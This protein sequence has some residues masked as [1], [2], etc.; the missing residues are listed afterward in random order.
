MVFCRLHRFDI[1]AFFSDKS[2]NA[3]GDILSAFVKIKI[4]KPKKSGLFNFF[5]KS[6]SDKSING[7]IPRHT[8]Q[9][10]HG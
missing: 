6:I 2:E 10:I 1:M 3:N 5:K 4:L 9:S 8:A 7:F